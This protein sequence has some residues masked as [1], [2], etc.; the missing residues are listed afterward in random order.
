MGNKIPMIFP[1]V[2]AGKVKTWSISLPGT[3]TS[4][5]NAGHEASAGLLQD[6]AFTIEGWFNPSATQPDTTF[7]FVDK[8]KVTTNTGWLLYSNA[9]SQIVFTVECATTDAITQSAAGLARDGSWHHIAAC[10]DDAGD[11]KPY[12]AI[13]GTWNNATQTAGVGA[14]VDDTAKDLKIGVRT[15]SAAWRMNGKVGWMRLSNVLRYTP[16]VNFSPASRSAPP[17]VDANTV[18]LFK[19]DEG[20][21]TVLTDY[22]A[23][24]QNAAINTGTWIKD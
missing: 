13:D 3:G 21:G 22:S 4:G 14:V 7:T 6:A 5:I 12:V 9:T 19:T 2:M 8:G 11:R 17:G 18:R 10:F 24:A 15:D 16:G 23:N 20:T 1:A